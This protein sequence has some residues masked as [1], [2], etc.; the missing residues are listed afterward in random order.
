MNERFSSARLIA[1]VELALEPD[2][3]LGP[4]LIRPS[5]REVFRTDLKTSSHA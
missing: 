2:F 5:S 3:S 1:R 4:V